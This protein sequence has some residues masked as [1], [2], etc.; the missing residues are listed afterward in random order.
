M[1]TERDRR[2]YRT[3][4]GYVYTSGSNA[5]G[6]VLALQTNCSKVRRY[7]LGWSSELRSDVIRTCD[8]N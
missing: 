6:S 4:S 8:A 7:S 1:Q 3:P 5:A 2:Q